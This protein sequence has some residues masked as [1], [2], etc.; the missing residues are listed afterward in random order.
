MP[1]LTSHP[2]WDSPVNQELLKVERALL[3]QQKLIQENAFKVDYY[4]EDT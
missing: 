3:K 4:N 1:I 2:D